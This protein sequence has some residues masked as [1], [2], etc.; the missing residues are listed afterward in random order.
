MLR[1][2]GGQWVSAGGPGGPSCQMELISVSSCELNLKN[3]QVLQWV[4][5]LEP[6]FEP[7]E[8]QGCEKSYQL[9]LPCMLLHRSSNRCQWLSGG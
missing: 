7:E 9:L 5:F 8:G 3:I 6:C 4:L 1:G 2:A